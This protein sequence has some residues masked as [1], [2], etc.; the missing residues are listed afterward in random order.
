M[1]NLNKGEKNIS[2]HF[3]IVAKLIDETVEKGFGDKTLVFITKDKELTY[4]E[5]NGHDQSSGERSFIF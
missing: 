2:Q 4:K 5:I 3:N 1:E